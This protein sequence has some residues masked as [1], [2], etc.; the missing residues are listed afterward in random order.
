M[1]AYFYFH[2][3]LLPQDRVGVRPHVSKMAKAVA[4]SCCALAMPLAYADEIEFNGAFLPEGSRS[5]NLAAYQKG[6]PVLPGVYRA[7]VALNGQLKSRQD[8]HVR[9]N[10]DGS[11]AVVCVSRKLLE[12]LGVDLTRL[13]PEALVFLAAGECTD[14]AKLIDGATA[15]F[16]PETQQVDI[17]I[18]QISLLRNARG[19][20]S[21]DVW[22]SGVTAGMLAYN[23]N[24]N[25]SRSSNTQY[26]SAYL[27]LDAGINLGSWRLRHKSALRWQPHRG[28]HYQAQDTYGRRDITALQ[29]QLT[30]GDA[31]TSGE[32]FDTQSF[33]GVQ[34]ASDDRMLPNSLRGYAPVVRGVARSNARVSIRQAGSI[35]LETTVA[36]GAFVIDD[37]YATGY[38]GDLTV[39][40][41]EADGSEQHFV[42]PYAAVSQL[43]R[44]GML[45]FGATAGITRNSYLSQQAHFL[46]GTA[47]YGLSNSMTGYGGVQASS[48]YF[49]LLGGMAFATPIGAI[50]ADVSHAH[51]KLVADTLRGQSLRLSYNKNVLSTGSN[52]ALAAYRFST[53]G[54]LD[55]TNAMQSLNAERRGYSTSVLDR[56]RNRLSLT[57]DQSLGHWGNLSMSGYT[58]NYWNRRGQDLQYQLSY[59]KQVGRIAYSIAASRGRMSYGGMEDRLLLTFNMPLG[60]Q[61]SLST[62]QLSTQLARNA[63]GRFNQMATLS[64]TTGDERQFGYGASV[65]R[66][67]SSGISSTV[68]GRYTGGQAL[69]GGS[70]GHGQGYTSASLSMSGSVV[71]HPGGVTLSPYS[72]ETMAVVHAPGAAGASIAG[73]PGLKLDARGNAVVPYLRPYELNEVAIDPAGTSMDIEM[74]ETSQQVAPREG[75]VVYLKY[76]TSKGR[77]VLFHVQLET[78]GALPFGATVIDELGHSVGVVGQDGQLYARLQ[79][80]SRQLSVT[81][82]ARAH[83]RCTLSIPASVMQGDSNQLRQVNAVCSSETDMRLAAAGSE[84]IPGVKGLKKVQP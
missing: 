15:V 76:G 16:V 23:F 25:H 12:L 24:S 39:T 79:E 32:V 28:S 59:S 49:S 8:I 34:L 10:A 64:G 53:R 6:N 31:H 5:L 33:R 22:D 82:G 74:L 13:A 47:Q 67:A 43:L 48:D 36:P 41:F 75:A 4:L 54:F 7:D 66:D 29:S 63:N 62:P 65:N 55:F 77:A 52:F 35:L 14:L 11:N 27:G 45:R 84:N 57:A 68:S 51:T 26:D 60:S 46:Q 61:N 78:G 18:P 38:G 1:N 40:V 30:V 80:S 19:Y 58:Q 2:C 21:P 73:Y 44:P 17:S 72:G 9:A 83:E 81:W 70:L 71:A 42:V 3:N 37:L 20:V 56:P 69:L 50:S